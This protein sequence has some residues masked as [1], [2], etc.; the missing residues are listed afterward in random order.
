M[1]Q[2]AITHCK[3]VRRE[4][5]W[6]MKL[7]N[8]PFGGEVVYKPALTNVDCPDLAVLPVE[9][10]YPINYNNWKDFYDPQKLFK[11]KSALRDSNFVH[12]WNSMKQ[13][14]FLGYTKDP[15]IIVLEADQ[16]WYYLAKEHC[17]HTENRFLRYLTGLPL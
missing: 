7:I 8:I 4:L 15:E 9:K 13:N 5:K 3:A 16:P 11:V 1:T 2:T 10:A 12:Y 6:W 17:P 14:G